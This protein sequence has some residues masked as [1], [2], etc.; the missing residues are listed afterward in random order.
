MN[1]YQD[2]PLI[3]RETFLCIVFEILT[4]TFPAHLQTPPIPTHVALGLNSN[5]KKGLLG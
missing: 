2:N 4:V 5:V 3:H 1:C